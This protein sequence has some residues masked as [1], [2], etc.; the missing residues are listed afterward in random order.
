MP[1][2]PSITEPPKKKSRRVKPHNQEVAQMFLADPKFQKNLLYCRSWDTFFL[3]NDGWY[4]QLDS[5]EM[6]LFVWNFAK[7]QYEGILNI[8]TALIGDIIT[9]IKWMSPRQ[10]EEIN[11]P[12]IAFDDKLV[13]TKTFGFEEFDRDKVAIHHINEV[14]DNLKTPTPV[15]E[16]FLFSTLVKDDMTTDPEL[17]GLAQEMFG[18]YLL[19]NLHAQVVFFLVGQGANGKS[20]MLHILEEMIGSKYVS[21]MSIQT[22]T[23]NQF[24]TSGLVGKKVNLC[25]EEES[26][27]LRS[28]KFKALISGDLIQAERKYEGQF[29]F[30]PQTKYI[31][32]SNQMPTFD[33]IN[34][35]IR[36]RMMIVPFKRIFKPEE[37]NKELA[38]ELLK[39]LP[40]IVGWALKGAERL[41]KNNYRFTYSLAVSESAIEFENYT[42]SSLMFFREN[43]QPDPEGFVDNEDLY[44]EYQ[45][46]CTKTGKRFLSMTH[47]NR[48]L[49]DNLNIARTSAWSAGKNKTVK[50][51]RASPRIEAMAGVDLTLEAI[52]NAMDES[53]PSLTQKELL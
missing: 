7:N 47:F 13:N 25:N 35:G 43:Y 26:K 42:S 19:N 37:Q 18:Y 17:V 51:H 20:V 11:T 38:D 15:F 5:R 22:L 6:S 46:W 16:Q 41:V 9:Q 45:E 33:G 8:T 39:E 52:N 50:G 2:E 34:H 40:G 10:V 3:Y 49:R 44:K 27:Y 36:R 31:F 24:A 4:R 29:T 23:L 14:T 21:A 53:S 30:R 32:A 1:E 28:D 12:Y 48:D